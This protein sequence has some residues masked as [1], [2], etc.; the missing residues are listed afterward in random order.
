MSALRK[1]SSFFATYCDLLLGN[2]LSPAAF[3]MVQ[4]KRN[5]PKFY[6]NISKLPK[7]VNIWVP[8]PSEVSL[9]RICSPKIAV[10]KA[11]FW[12]KMVS[13]GQTIHFGP[14]SVIHNRK[15]VH[16]T[17]LKHWWEVNFR[18]PLSVRIFGTHPDRFAT[19]IRFLVLRI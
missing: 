12:E 16:L 8:A 3:P 18:P 17:Y 9:S 5:G 6:G 11:I 7:I 4:V 2:F 1:T 15:A 10:L 19:L 13:H 14:H